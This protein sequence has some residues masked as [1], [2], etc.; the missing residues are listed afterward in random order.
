MKF[1]HTES[2]KQ[3]IMTSEQQK[4]LF[5]LNYLVSVSITVCLALITNYLTESGVVTGNS[6]TEALE[7]SMTQALVFM[8]W[9]FT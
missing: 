1:F 3:M 5:N 2:E 6:Q 8:A 4:H 7:S 9:I